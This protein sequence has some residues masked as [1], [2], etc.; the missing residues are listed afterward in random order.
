[1]KRKHQLVKLFNE[2]AGKCAYC[3]DDMTLA[4]GNL[5]T[6]TREHIIPKSVIKIGDKFN[7]VAACQE[8]N[9]LKSDM[10]LAAFIGLLA[11]RYA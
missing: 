7:M 11:R 2:Q 10:P 1:M 9:S 3:G 5:K 6:A 4:L 8:C